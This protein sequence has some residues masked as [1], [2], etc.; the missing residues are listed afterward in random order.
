MIDQQALKKLKPEE[1]VTRLKEMA[2]ERKREL[3]F[4]ETLLKDTSAELRE[5]HQQASQQD[6]EATLTRQLQAATAEA[7]VR[8]RPEEQEKQETKQGLDGRLQDDS[9]NTVPPEERSRLAH[10]AEAANP[11]GMYQAQSSTG[12]PEIKKE[13]QAFEEYSPFKQ[14]GYESLWKQ[15]E[16]SKFKK[17]EQKKEERNPSFL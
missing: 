3:Q 17:H 1:R 14:T 11:A 12:V 9:I 10:L 2:E 7:S 16:D 8:A 13:Y 15:E 4:I 6:E 5:V